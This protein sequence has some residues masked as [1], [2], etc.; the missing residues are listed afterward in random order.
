MEKPRPTPAEIEAL[1]TLIKEATNA[2][3]SATAFSAQRLRSCVDVGSTLNSWKTSIPRGEWGEFIERHF[4][5]LNERTS[6]RWMR[7]AVAE[8]SGTLNL[9]SARGLRHA[10]QLAGLLPDAESSG[11]SKGSSKAHS[12][13]V[14]IAR[15]VAGLQHI[16][17]DLLSPKDRGELRDRLRPLA[18]FIK[19]LEA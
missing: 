4:P 3:D 16:S 6:Q 17:L 5:D 2:G 14:H 8:Q 13:V 18:E 12:W 9:D 1:A 15:L 7:L 19:R 10:Y 11:N